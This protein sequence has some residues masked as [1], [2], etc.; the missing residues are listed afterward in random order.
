MKWLWLQTGV[1]TGQV[2]HDTFSMIQ[3]TKREMRVQTPGKFASAQ[4]MPHEIMPAKKKRPS[5][6]LTFSKNIIKII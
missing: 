1:V 3:G 5:A 2:Y 6:D 4:P